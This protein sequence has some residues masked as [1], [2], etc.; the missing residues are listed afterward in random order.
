ME[1]R[2]NAWTYLTPG[3]TLTAKV[4]KSILCLWCCQQPEVKGHTILQVPRQDCLCTV[5]VS[6]IHNSWWRGV[7]V[8]SCSPTRCKSS[9][10]RVLWLVSSYTTKPL[11][12]VHRQKGKKPFR[13]LR[14][15]KTDLDLTVEG[16]LHIVMAFAEKL[17]AG[18]HSFVFSKPFYT[19]MQERDVLMTFW[20]IP[21]PALL[22][23]GRLMEAGV[24][25]F[26]CVT[27]MHARLN[28]CLCFAGMKKNM[29]CL[30][31]FKASKSI[32]L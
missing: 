27:S 7:P 23:I 2:V 5:A 24:F 12:S 26:F 14:N 20:L 30:D 4:E 25:V 29:L 22:C 9:D 15:L 10:P 16:D 17:R 21:P 3:T 19:S 6:D 8:H 13:S 1:I 28:M 18:L 31:Q 11:L 32:L